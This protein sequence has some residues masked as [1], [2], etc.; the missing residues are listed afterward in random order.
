MLCDRS[1]HVHI[2]PHIVWSWYLVCFH[3]VIIYPHIGVVQ[4]F[5][6]TFR[7][8]CEGGG[9][10]H[11][12][13]EMRKRRIRKKKKRRRK[14][15]RKKKKGKMTD[16]FFFFF[17]FFLYSN[18]SLKPPQWG[19][20]DAEI[21]VPSGENTELKRSPFKAW[22]RSVYSHTCCAYCQGFLPLLISTLPIHSPSFFSK[23]S[24]D[25]SLCWLWLT[26]GSCVGP[27]NKI[28]HPAGW[29]FPCWV[30]TEY[31]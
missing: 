24:P 18:C 2:S 26:H 27:Q 28:G 12:D 31:K 6:N 4:I 14:K 19:A 13:S 10:K 21:K 30:P 15:E 23:T 22:S 9:P 17:F 11:A 20:A 7:L 16:P 3:T 1:Y 8:G 25:F 5:L 29:R